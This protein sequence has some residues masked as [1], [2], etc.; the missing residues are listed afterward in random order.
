MENRLQS[1]HPAMLTDEKLLEQCELTTLRRSGPGG[2]N[3]NKVETAVVLKHLPTGIQAQASERRSQS[4]NR[5]VALKRLREG[6]AIGVRSS[7]VSD[8]WQDGYR[9]SERWDAHLSSGKIS[10]SR[11]SSDFPYLLAELLD[12]LAWEQGDL[13]RIAQYLG[14][15]VSQVVRLV[16]QEPA[17]LRW[18]NELRSALGMGSLR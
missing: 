12:F 8:D 14:T 2:Q 4:E 10:L 3:R 6:L 5:G 11:D 18:V 13:N 7:K 15:T 16:R 17:A 9:K 1:S